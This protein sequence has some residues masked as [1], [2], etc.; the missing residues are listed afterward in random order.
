MFWCDRHQ[1]QLVRLSGTANYLTMFKP[2]NNKQA[3]RTKKRA[4]EFDS[5]LK[6]NG[7]FEAGRQGWMESLDECPT[8]TKAAITR[9]E[10]DKSTKR[11]VMWTFEKIVEFS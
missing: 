5:G 6:R 8:R 7:R 3:N 1:V 10:V 9:Q 11:K 4:V 2:K